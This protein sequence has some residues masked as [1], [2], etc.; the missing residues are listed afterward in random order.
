MLQGRYILYPVF[1]TFFLDNLGLALVYPIFTPLFLRPQLGFLTLDTS[2]LER[3]VLLGFLISCFSFAQ[4][5]GAPLIGEISDRIGRKKTF[6]I[7]ISGL[8]LSYVLTA[9]SV[10]LNFV[11][12][13]FIARLFTGFFA[14]NQTLC[15]AA[16]ADISVDEKTRAKNFGF[17]GAAGG[18]SFIMGILLGG[19]LAY[20]KNATAFMPSLPF[21]IIA[22]LSFL[23]LI[24]MSLLFKESHVVSP[25]KKFHFFKGIKHLK[26][27]LRIPSLRPIYAVYFLFTFSWVTSMQ[28]LPSFLIMQYGDSTQIILF[29]FSMI[30]LTWFLSNSF[31]NR[32]LSSRYHPLQTVKCALLLVGCLLLFSLLL[33]PFPLFLTSFLLAGFCSALCWSNTLATVSLTAPKDMQGSV[34]GINQS[35]AAASALA[36]PSLGGFLAGFNIHYVY[37][38]TAMTPFLAFVLLAKKPSAQ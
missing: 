34:L 13:L 12:L 16:I 30:G 29:V 21:W 17:I 9:L 19:S 3:T 14:G 31:I 20:P 28:F 2:L 32:F 38:F 6:Y 10:L 36:G 25:L 33:K 24:L 15:L 18:L 26:E 27:A 1:L 11:P 22:C 5:F 8:T 23:N 35:V 4:F 37:L 7:T